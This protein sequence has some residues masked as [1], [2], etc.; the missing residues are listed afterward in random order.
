MYHRNNVNHL[1]VDTIWHP[2]RPK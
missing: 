1:P 2:R